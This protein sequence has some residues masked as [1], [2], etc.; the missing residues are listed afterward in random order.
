MT[1]E[2]A[3][4]SYDR[5]MGR[6]SRPLAEEF[7]AAAGIS[8]PQRVLD[9]GC[10]PGALTEALVRVL[11]AASVIAVDPSA[12]FVVAARDRLPGVEVHQAAAE[13]LPAADDSFDAAL[14]QLVVQFMADPVQGLSEMRRVTRAG[15]ALGA[16]VWDHGGGAGPLSLFWRAVAD[17]DPTSPNEDQRPG[18]RAGQLVELTRRAGW[19]AVEQSRLVVRLSFPTFDEWWQPYTLGVG[20][21]G[22]HV[23]RLDQ[24]G[25][26]RLRE[27]CRQLLPAEPFEIVA[28]AWCV[29]GRA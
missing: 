17:I 10:G 8:A 1:F 6:F 12:P 4:N 5:F 29:I 24:V 14:A 19:S 13:A 20:P 3:A 16:C 9:V 27:R 2:V 11:G 18:V 15:G 25:R 26:E 7:L 21:A 22:D 28:A 23:A